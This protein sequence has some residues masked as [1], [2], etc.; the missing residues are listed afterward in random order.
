MTLEAPT[1]VGAERRSA[2]ISPRVRTPTASFT[3]FDV[4]DVRSRAFLE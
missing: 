4:V 1:R 3:E 2:G